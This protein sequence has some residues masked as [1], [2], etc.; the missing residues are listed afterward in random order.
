MSCR[1]CMRQVGPSAP[2]SEPTRSGGSSDCTCQV[3]FRASQLPFAQDSETSALTHV[4]TAEWDSGIGAWMMPAEEESHL[5]AAQRLLPVFH[6]AEQLPEAPG[7]ILQ[8]V[9]L[10]GV[11]NRR[12]I[13][14]VLPLLVVAPPLHGLAPELVRHQ[15]AGQSVHLTQTLR[16]SCTSQAL[17]GSPTPIPC[18]APSAGLSGRTL[19]KTTDV[20]M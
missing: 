11:P 16:G 19:R 9:A 14:V 8:P 13:C 1:V 3:C 5:G 20:S 12:A 2:W 18:M 7:H 15:P 17:H 6:P 4:P 10:R